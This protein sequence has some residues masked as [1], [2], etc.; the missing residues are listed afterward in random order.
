M[1]SDDVSHVITSEKCVFCG[2]YK[3]KEMF[4]CEILGNWL[5]CVFSVF[6]VLCTLYSTTLCNFENFL[7]QWWHLSKN[8]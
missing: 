3:N 5:F 2:K 7:S 4:K 1:L 6:Y 8:L